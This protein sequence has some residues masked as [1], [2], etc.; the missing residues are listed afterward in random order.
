MTAIVST[1]ELPWTFLFPVNMKRDIDST[2]DLAFSLAFSLACSLAC[3]LD[4]LHRKS[5]EKNH[6]QLGLFP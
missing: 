1:G 5:Y 4:G 3:S 2:R 6:H